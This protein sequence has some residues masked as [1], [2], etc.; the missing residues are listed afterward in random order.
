V[1]RTCMLAILGALIASTARAQDTTTRAGPRPLLQPATE[2]ALARSAAPPSVAARARVLVLTD[3]GYAVA[4]SGRS[5]E[6]VVCVVNRSWRASIEPHCYDAEAA[7][8]V[9]PVEL[10][11]NE[12]RH[13]SI[14]E[15]EIE[16]ELAAGLAA[17]TYR[18]P[19]R[20]A[21]T[22]MMSP[23]QV[24]YDDAGRR[25]GAWRPHLM[26]YYPYLTNA[27][28]GLATQPD[29]RVGMVS[30]EGTPASTLV[31]VMPDFAPYEEP[32]PE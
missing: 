7:A 1:P 14:P 2:I 22:Y 13:R 20:P 3:S 12:M 17:G 31:I 9:M 15:A 28:V 24:L 8:T 25:V 16:R 11:R 6:G 27:Q 26:I 4:D 23:R 5:A 29:M 19:S 21:M 32:R 10:R 18:L 30:D